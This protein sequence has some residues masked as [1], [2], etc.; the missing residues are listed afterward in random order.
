MIDIEK[1]ISPLVEFHFPAF[2][3]EE[4]PK[5][6]AFVKAY[7]EWLEQSE[8]II[9]NEDVAPK[10]LHYSRNLFEIKDIDK[11]PE[12]FLNFFKNKFLRGVSLTSDTDT[13]NLVKHS[14]ELYRS[15]G[16]ERSVELLFSLLFGEEIE[17][18]LPGRDMLRVS[19]GEWY[20]PQYIELEP[21]DKSRTFIGKQLVGASSGSTAIVEGFARR[22]VRGKVIDV[23]FLSSIIGNFSVGEL[24]GVEGVAEDDPIIVGSLSRIIINASGR[25]FKVGDVVDLTSQI[26]GLAGKARVSA[27]SSAT[28]RVNYR[29]I[30]GGTGYSTNA[31]VV[32][33]EK[34]LSTSSFNSVN[35]FLTAFSQQETIEQPLANVV[36]LSP[37]GNLLDSNNLILGVNSTPAPVVAGYVYNGNTT[38]PTTKFLSISVHEVVNAAIGSVTNANTSGSFNI[39]ETVIQVSPDTGTNSFLGTIVLANSSSALI[40][41]TVGNIASNSILFGLQSNCNA[42]VTSSITINGSFD[43]ADDIQ[44]AGNSAIG[45]CIISSVTNETATAKVI[46]SNA[47]TLGVYDIQNTFRA[48]SLFSKA[49][50]KN[51]FKTKTSNVFSVSV[52][53]PGGFDIGAIVDTEDILIN[54]D[55]IGGNN[56]NGVPYLSINLDGSNSDVGFVDSIT[57]NDGGTSFDNTDLVIFSGGS[58]TVNASGTVTTSANG[59]IDFITIT[60]PGSGYSSTPTFTITQIDG[61]TPSTGSSANLVVNMDFGYG[62]PKLA[63]GDL[64]TIINLALTRVNK[65]VGTIASLTN[66]NPGANNN[67]S[68]YVFIIERDI[69][70]FGRKNFSLTLNNVSQPFIIGE[71][72][73][74]SINEPAVNLQVTDAGAFNLRETIEQ[75]RS[76]GNVVFGEILAATISSNTGTLLIKVANTSNTFDTSNTITGLETFATANIANVVVTTA[77]TVGKGEIIGTSALLSNT[78]ILSIKRKQ[79]NVSFTSNAAIFGSSSGAQGNVV[80]ISEISDSSIM[81]NNA[82][83]DSTAGTAN[84]VI[85]GIEVINSG[86]AYRENELVT[87]TE[88]NNQFVASGFVRLEKQGITEGAYQSTKGFLNSNKVIQ[89][90]RFYQEYSYE[91]QAG[92][93]LDKYSQVLRELVHVAGTE[94]FGSVLKASQADLET[95]VVES[96]ITVA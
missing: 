57:V 67:A 69:A 71:E 46:G 36:I 8:Y 34:V 39:G 27:V 65:T 20:K 63:D 48:P 3:R 60:T 2:Y 26:S 58:P 40:D 74:Q 5:F 88:P 91:V 13:R 12:E 83:I 78:L 31:E 90:S 28:G 77:V 29:L 53:N 19:D 10:T 81:G 30:D 35:S 38:D 22:N 82:I 56:V 72:I 62:F 61:V 96:T 45:N 89:D 7:Y 1:K 15:K 17:I 95:N 47:S 9:N 73:T 64:T 33:S 37:Q 23:L 4:G 41:V 25:D 59:A 55:F 85:E 43:D 52:G 51:T 94:L 76:D 84:G 93:S 11:T 32:I 70:G 66:I 54:S 14:L 86:F 21:N 16:S 75:T 80:Q 42:N 68:P 92:I 18:Y 6:I 44:T 50:V 24:V 79:F 87:I 49:Y